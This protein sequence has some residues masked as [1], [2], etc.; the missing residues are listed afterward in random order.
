MALMPHIKY[1]TVNKK[2]DSTNLY[3][4]LLANS[5]PYASPHS[6]PDSH[7]KER[8]CV[9]VCVKIFCPANFQ[10]FVNN[11]CLIHIY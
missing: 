7:P 1:P 11:V 2:C 6:T 10:E 3:T 5:S 4:G 8:W 9:S